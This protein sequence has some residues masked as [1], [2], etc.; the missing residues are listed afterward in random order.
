MT[1]NTPLAIFGRILG[2]TIVAIGTLAVLAIPSIIHY[3]VYGY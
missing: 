3:L 2:Y 1:T